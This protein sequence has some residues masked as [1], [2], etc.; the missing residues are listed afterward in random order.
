MQGGFRGLSR[1]YAI[2]KPP[3]QELAILKEKIYKHLS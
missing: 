1:L 2:G 3:F